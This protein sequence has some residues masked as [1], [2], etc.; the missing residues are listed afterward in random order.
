[1]GLFWSM[2]SKPGG[3]NRRLFKS[4]VM[5]PYRVSIQVLSGF[6][7]FE[8][9]PWE[10]SEG[11]C[12]ASRQLL[13]SY[14]KPGVK[15]VILEEDGLYGTLFFPPGEGPFPAVMDM[16]G[17]TNEC[18]ELRSALLASHGIASFV[19]KYIG[20]KDLPNKDRYL[21]LHYFLRAFDFLASHPNVDEHA[22]G[23]IATCAGASFL[24]LIAS[25]RP[26]MKCCVM[27]NGILYPLGAT[28]EVEGEMINTLEVLLREAYV[29]DDKLLMQ[30]IYKPGYE[31]LVVPGWR[32]GAKMLFIQGLGDE[33]VGPE[34]LERLLPLIP[35][36]FSD[37]VKV[38][39]YAGAGHLLEPPFSPHALFNFNPLLE[40]NL[41]WGGDPELHA[42]AQEDSWPKILNFLH[43]NLKNG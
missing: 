1:M 28:Q 2:R 4:D 32:H 16:F 20:Y 22:L 7:N 21:D 9:L 35:S 12:L 26:K 23:G 30:T 42:R 17:F 8:D 5:S 38:L 3:P 39:K 41:V 24:L 33:S 10:T 6:W 15:R 29:V 14:C 13:R 36:S 40:K 34:C 11:V 27:I 25:K 43:E 37:S 18:L 19:L 31:R